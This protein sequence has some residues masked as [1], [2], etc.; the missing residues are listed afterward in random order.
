MAALLAGDLGAYVIKAQ[1]PTTM[2]MAL[3]ASEDRRSST[4]TRT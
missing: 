1:K 3:R 2:A 4:A